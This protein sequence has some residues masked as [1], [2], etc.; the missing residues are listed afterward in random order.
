MADSGSMQNALELRGPAKN[1]QLGGVVLII[2]TI[3]G[4]MTIGLEFNVG[5]LAR[6]VETTPGEMIALFLELWDSLRWIWALQMIAAF[7]SAVGAFVLVGA[8]QRS[9]QWLPAQLIWYAIAIGYV[10]STVSYALTLGSYPPALAAAEQHPELFTTV[11]GGI[12]FLY[13]VGGYTQIGLFVLFY[14]EGI[15]RKGIVPPSW[16]LGATGVFIIAIALVVGGVVHPRVA[17]PVGLIVPVLLG[18]AY[19][20]VGR[21]LAT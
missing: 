6:S 20:R 21:E 14:W 5:W 18:L 9:R 7:L 17:G 16:V 13:E 12:R 2:G 15:S 8:P 11:R 1:A 10:L 19:W 3:L 4:L